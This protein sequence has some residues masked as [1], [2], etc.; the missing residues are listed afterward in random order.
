MENVQV[1]VISREDNKSLCG[2]GETGEL[3]IRAAGLSAGYL[4][5]PE[6][7]KQ[8]F[9][10]NWFVDNQKWVEA[11]KA[12]D[13]GEPWRAY[14]NGPHDKLYRTGDLGQYLPSGAVRV[15]GRIDSQVK[16]SGH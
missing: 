6:L 9:V 10:D 11:D 15:S 7:N 8:K 1:L 13:K 12:M 16:V 4:N 14:Y 3:M 2:V 5:D